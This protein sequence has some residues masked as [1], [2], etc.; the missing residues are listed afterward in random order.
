MKK[1]CVKCGQAKVGR[2]GS[3]CLKCT[4][5]YH[6]SWRSRNRE[7]DKA[8]KLAWRRR[9]KIKALTHYSGGKPKCNCCGEQEVLFLT[10]DHINNDGA[11]HRKAMKSVLAATWLRLNNY[12]AGFQVLC[13]NCNCGKSINKGVCPHLT[14][15][16][17]T[18]E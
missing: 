5:E 11:H 12:P 3:R 6:L 16:N 10:F 14:T 13:F 15:K 2:G 18:H 8:N 7:R 4:R 9:N 1:L 17:P